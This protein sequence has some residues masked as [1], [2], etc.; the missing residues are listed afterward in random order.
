MSLTLQSV[1]Y[2]NISQSTKQS[3]YA[4][5]ISSVTEIQP[6]ESCGCTMVCND[7]TRWFGAEKAELKSQ[8]RPFSDRKNNIELSLSSQWSGNNAFVLPELMKNW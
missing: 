2:S 4:G 8:E 3:L 5:I 7:I 6:P 1:I